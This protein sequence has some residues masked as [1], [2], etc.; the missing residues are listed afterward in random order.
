MRRGCCRSTTP[1][2]LLHTRC[3][4]PFYVM[5]RSQKNILG[6]AREP[7]G[8]KD[9]LKAARPNSM[10]LFLTL[11]DCKAQS[12]YARVPHYVLGVHDN[13]GP[14]KTT[15]GYPSPILKLGSF[16]RFHIYFQVSRCFQTG[17]SRYDTICV[18]KL[19][20]DIL[21]SITR[22]CILLLQA[23]EG[24]RLNEFPTHSRFT[25]GPTLHSCY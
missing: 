25:W 16:T 20:V 18:L 9:V 11:L 17:S 12:P 22:I 8:E 13:S 10:I 3:L 4:G 1:R 23:P 24:C 2:A 15:P 6:E 14:P 7:Q 5:P 21:L 19:L